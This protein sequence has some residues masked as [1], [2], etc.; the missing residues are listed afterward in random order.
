M[1]LFIILITNKSTVVG[2]WNIS[3]VNFSALKDWTGRRNVYNG[4]S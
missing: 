1:H 2:K 4:C 3:K